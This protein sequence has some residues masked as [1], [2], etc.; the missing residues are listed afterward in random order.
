MVIKMGDWK[1]KEW[2]AFS[3]ELQNDA[4]FNVIQTVLAILRA[5]L[6]PKYKKSPHFKYLFFWYWSANLHPLNSIIENK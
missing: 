3:N 2:E 4:I 6:N 1:C 5:R